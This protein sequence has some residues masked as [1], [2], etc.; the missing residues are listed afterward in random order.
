MARF[1]ANL[2]LYRRIHVWKLE[3][4]SRSSRTIVAPIRRIAHSPCYP[5][6]V[7]IRDQRTGALGVIDIDAERDL[8]G[9]RLSGSRGLHS[10]IFVVHPS[11]AIR[12]LFVRILP[13]SRD[14]LAGWLLTS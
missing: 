11:T 13:E 1:H 2:V 4:G 9:S 6:R 10:P 7:V 5:G 12:L 8:L 14:F 3:L